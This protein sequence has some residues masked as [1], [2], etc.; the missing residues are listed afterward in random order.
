MMKLSLFRIAFFAVLLAAL[1]GCHPHGR[2]AGPSRGKAPETVELRW[3][4]LPPV[5]AS[6]AAP[7]SLTAA[8]GSGI[9][10]VTLKA[11]GT[12]EGPLAFTELTLIFENPSPRVLEGTF[13]LTLPPTASVHRFAMR[14]GGVLQEGEIVERQKAEQTFEAFMHQRV[15]PALLEQQPGNQFRARV[16]P[17][18][19]REQKEIVLAY[20]ELL[21]K[22]D[23]P[24]RLYLSGLPTLDELDIR[25]SVAGNEGYRLFHLERELVT[26]DRDFV[27]PETARSGSPALARAGKFA[28]ARVKMQNATGTDAIDDL[29]IAVDTSASRAP[30]LRNQVDQLGRFLS[31]LAARGNPRVRVLAFDQ[32]T[33]EVFQGRASEFGHPHAGTMLARGAGGATDFSKALGSLR[34]QK[35]LLILSD[36]IFTAGAS[37]LP[38]WQNQ[39]RA[40]GI[41]RLDV[42]LAGA[43]RDEKAA[44]KLTTTGLRTGAL[45]EGV[46]SDQAFERL[47][48]RG[49]SPL[50]IRV[51]NSS[52]SFPERISAAGGRDEALV[53]AELTAEGPF[54]VVLEGTR[55]AFPSSVTASPALVERALARAR[56]EKLVSDHA[57]TSDEAIRNRIQRRVVSL[58]RK[59]QVLSPF[60]SLL[61]LESEEDYARFG[62]DRNAPHE[63]MALGDSGGVEIVGR[64]REALP[65]DVQGGLS[66][67]LPAGRRGVDQ[68]KDA[69]PDAADRCPDTPETY[70]GFEDTDGCPDK[71]R[72]IIE[73]SNIIILEAI[74][75]ETGTA[76]IL[77]ESRPIIDAV[78]AT[79][80][81]HPEFLLIEV[82]GYT[83]AMGDPAR[84]QRL[85]EQRAQAVQQALL[86]GGIA[87]TRIIAR[88]YGQRCPRAENASA[89]GRNANRRVEFR[90]LKTEDGDTGVQTCSAREPGPTPPALK[91]AARLREQIDPAERPLER[92]PAVE[93]ELARIRAL[94]AQGHTDE[95]LRAAK[96]YRDLKPAEE[97]S[98]VALGDV[99]LK[100][101]DLRGAARAY[102]SLIDLAGDS[103]PKRRAAA[104]WL[105]A[106]GH[107][108]TKSDPKLYADALA[109]AVDSYRWAL[110]RRRDQP[111]SHELYAY[112][113]AKQGKLDQA[114][115][116]LVKALGENFDRRFGNARALL[117]A[118]LGMVAAARVARAPDTR[119]DIDRQLR[120]LGVQLA[121]KPTVRFVLSWESDTSD[122]N[123]LVSGEN[124][125]H[126]SVSSNVRDGFGPEQVV[127]TDLSTQP[128]K[129]A[130][131]YDRRGFQ[132]YA[133]GKVT[134]VYFDGTG[135][136]S[137]DDRPFVLM[138]EHGSQEL[139]EFRLP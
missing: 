3:E 126:S 66:G 93:G 122:V 47:L 12:V 105:E 42:A 99:E 64:A 133:L 28:V 56:I 86:R 124:R 55:Y 45:L 20:S 111:S 62:I 132:G 13:A 76:T 121:A 129:L 72:V 68:D 96:A 78:V 4:E 37:G 30:E 59:H 85:S 10:L 5:R 41:E 83:D 70:N 44:K 46:A 7:I 61:V 8:D 15:D 116:V 6:R 88:G 101:G 36:G 32:E 106:V 120:A 131:T 115:D 31:G 104:G 139:G 51:P 69:I 14:I 87:P 109:L 102:G 9:E 114:F 108:A 40:A 18:A 134:I 53:F 50:R 98:W 74:Q 100:K 103:A 48:R 1:A 77:P 107:R 49:T 39:A 95:A 23:Q 97:L 58:S 137:F 35:R 80:K 119:D 130:V 43:T 75:F 33:S 112:A 16:F 84:N 27:L 113:L 123:L 22:S 82:A 21:E 136:L 11:R 71:G 118:D 63:F 29:A 125:R 25:V 90:I 79:L 52:F 94:L 26:P 92:A 19:P 65:S 89:A 34:G 73:S 24:Y 38:D 67:A 2:A 110:E 17:I 60:T 128:Q 57:A 54:E 91:P 138:K 81:G 127:L 135:G 117:A